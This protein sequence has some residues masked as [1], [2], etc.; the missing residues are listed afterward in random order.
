MARRSAAD[1]AQT[2]AGILAAARRQF[3]ENGYAATT[4][5]QIAEAAGVTVGALF[6]HFD[7]KPGL[8]RLVFEEIE[9]ELDASIR[10]AAEP[11]TAVLD[12]FLLGFR[13]YLEFARRQEFYRIVMLEG[14][15]VLGQSGWLPL[16]MS[17]GAA[18]LMEGLE[19]LVAEGIIEQ[20][21][22]RPLALL[23]LGATVEAG[24]E[25][26]R[27]ASPAELD[28]MVEAMRY[29]LSPHLR[30][31]SPAGGKAP[32]RAKTPARKA[33]APSTKAGAGATPGPGKTGAGSTPFAARPRPAKAPPAK[34]PRS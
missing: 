21:P 20:R 23:L 31:P 10:A 16:D 8:F 19:A 25:A 32:P 18:T 1:A 17:R 28:A 15:V 27:G 29:L 3:A 34:K 9:S 24:L 11:A 26:A 7:G 13:A 2:R 14:P 30:A 33:G 4:T 5:G 12:A 22:L 6:H